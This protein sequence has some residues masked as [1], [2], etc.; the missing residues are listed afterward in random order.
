[1][2]VYEMENPRDTLHQ[3]FSLSEGCFEDKYQPD[4]GNILWGIREA[5][6]TP[7]SLSSGD[8]YNTERSNIVP[9]CSTL[10]D[11]E[12]AQIWQY[13]NLMCR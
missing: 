10:C 9:S 3:H 6:L 12:L 7:K 8:W 11:R 4:K 2:K 1:M 5:I 13:S